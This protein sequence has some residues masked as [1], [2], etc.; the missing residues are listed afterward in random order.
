MGT[1]RARIPKKTTEPVR[2]AGYVRISAEN[3][4]QSTKLKSAIRR[5][6]EKQKLHVAS[7]YLDRHERNLR[8]SALNEFSEVGTK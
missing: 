4:P 1:V 5:Y 7:I 2:A 3:H 8:Q 6:A